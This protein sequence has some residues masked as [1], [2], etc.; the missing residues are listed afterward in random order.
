MVTVVSLAWL[1]FW[2][3][4]YDLCGKVVF[5]S[6]VVSI[7]IVPAES[8]FVIQLLMGHMDILYQSDNPLSIRYTL[9][10]IL[11]SV[12]SRFQICGECLKS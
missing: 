1:I 2:E 8:D 9:P 3:D 10:T 11:R 6:K 5:R 12:K 7:I 4:E